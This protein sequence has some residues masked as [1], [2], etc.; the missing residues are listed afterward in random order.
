MRAIRCVLLGAG[1]VAILSLSGAW[2]LADNILFSDD[3]E[4]TT[5]G[6]LVGQD[7]WAVYSD[8]P[9]SYSTQVALGSDYGTQAADTTRMI[10]LNSNDAI[11]Q[12]VFSTPL[13]FTSADTAV[14][15]SAWVES[16]ENAQT[17]DNGG[18]QF[19]TSGNHLFGLFGEDTGKT[20]FREHN[21]TQIWGASLKQGD[22]YQINLVMDF[23][24]GNGTLFYR[25]VSAGQ[26]AFTQDTTIGTD[27]VFSLGLSPDGS[28]NYVATAWDLRGNGGTGNTNYAFMDNLSVSVPGGAVPEPSTLALLAAGL[29]GLSVSAWR[30]RK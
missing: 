9:T 24:T 14:T 20:Y 29:I 6:A 19:T 10:V 30:K 22:W 25:D 21:G 17:E 2:A 15:E 26:T 1:V 27:G 3:F 16:N 8:H 18:L 4:T 13:T 11:A 12:K 23:A 5:A 28:G 7:G